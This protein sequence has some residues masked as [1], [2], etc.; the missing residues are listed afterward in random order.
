MVT[1]RN[2]KAFKTKNEAA[3]YLHLKKLINI[4]CKK[5]VT[6]SLIL[7]CTYSE[8]VV[9]NCALNAF[10]KYELLLIPI[11]NITSVIE[12]SSETRIFATI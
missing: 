3:E 7:F 12:T 5:T 9:P 6:N 11:L 8:S 2:I 4:L 10:V 1:G